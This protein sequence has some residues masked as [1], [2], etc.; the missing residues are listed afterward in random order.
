ME[1]N[2]PGKTSANW[3]TIKQI[4]KAS[5]ASAGILKPPSPGGFYLSVNIRGS[6][7]Y[8]AIQ[9]PILNDTYLYQGRLGDTITTADGFEAA[10]LCALNILCH[11]NNEVGFDKIKGLNHIDVYY[12]QAAGWDE[13]PK[14][15]DGA[16]ETFLQN[17]GGMGLHSR[18]IIGVQNLPRNFCIGVVSSF[19][20][21]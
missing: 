16:S 10:K 18:A 12:Q 17:L 9:F 14:V 5:A 21:N 1:L 7:A 2:I 20:L 4:V 13:G 6:I 15:A 11:I 19:T 8:V 3:E